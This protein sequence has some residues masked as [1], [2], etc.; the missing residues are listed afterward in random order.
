VSHHQFDKVSLI[1]TGDVGRV[2]L[3]RDS[4]NKNYYAMKVLNK[5]EM[6]KRNKIKRVLAEQEILVGASLSIQRG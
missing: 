3:V 6:L 5:K 1:G 2:Y 4:T